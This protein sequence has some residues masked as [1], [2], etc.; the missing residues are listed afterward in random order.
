MVE[1]GAEK[2]RDAAPIAF[3]V[4]LTGGRIVM[5]NWIPGDRPGGADP[6]D[7]LSLCAAAPEGFLQP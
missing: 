4:H 6:E 3:R 7:Q 2:S 5:G 1:I